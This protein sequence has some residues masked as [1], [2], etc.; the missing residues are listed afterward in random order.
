MTKVNQVRETTENGDI[1]LLDCGDILG[2]KDAEE[3]EK[4]DV[5]FAA[6]ERL[7]YAAMNLGMNE[8]VLG[9]DKLKDIRS[10]ISIPMIASNLIVRKD[11]LPIAERYVIKKI[12]NITIGILGVVPVEIF[13]IN[14]GYGHADDFL[15]TDPEIEL[16]KLVPEIRNK[17]DFLILL[18]QCGNKGTETLIDNVGGIDLAI[19]NQT[20]PITPDAENRVVQASLRA[21]ALGSLVLFFGKDNKYDHSLKQPLALD[22]QVKSDEELEQSL[23]DAKTKKKSGNVSLLK[24]K[25]KNCT[26]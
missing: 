18:S 14:S 23:V 26:S 3:P 21:E 10:K 17:V 25:S 9:A 4:V 19:T 11:G 7:G 16:K 22:D 2:E 15:I 5:V 12:G 13:N 6:M 8:L 1:F 24:I 20:G